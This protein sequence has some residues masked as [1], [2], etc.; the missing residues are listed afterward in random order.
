[1]FLSHVC[2][3]I[4]TLSLTEEA[5]HLEPTA[6]ILQNYFSKSLNTLTK[7]LLKY[8]QASLKVHVIRCLSRV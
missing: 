2:E 4:N 8:R 7:E 6:A 5:S 3:S 1:M